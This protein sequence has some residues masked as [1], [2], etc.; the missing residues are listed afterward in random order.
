MKEF[1]TYRLTGTGVWGYEFFDM[2]RNQIGFVRNALSRAEPVRIEGLGC[3]WY[4]RFG[5]DATI[6]PGTGRRVK[7]NRTGQEV[8]RIIYWQPRLYQVRPE[9]GNSAQVEIRDGSYGTMGT[10]LFVPHCKMRNRG[11]EQRC[12]QGNRGTVFFVPHSSVAELLNQVLTFLGLIGVLVDPTT[13]GLGD[14]E[15]AMSYEEPWNDNLNH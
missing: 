3:S 14:S 5:L 7:D 9:I 6:V 15:R 1:V 10:V 8:Y 2:E 12:E 13:A 4:S 11:A